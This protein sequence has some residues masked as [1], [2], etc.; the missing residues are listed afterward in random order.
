M[1]RTAIDTSPPRD[2]NDDF[3]D[4]VVA[5]RRTWT[6]TSI[7]HLS[8]RAVPAAEARGNVEQFIGHAQIPV[9]VVG[10]LRLLGDFEG[11]YA[12]PMATCEG[13]MV[14]SYQRG[15]KACADG[16]RVRVL[17]DGLI[18][19]PILTFDS[20]D[21]AIAAGRF[22]DA[23]RARLVAAA[24]ATT[25]H[26]KVTAL[27]W[28]ILGRRLLLRLEMTTGDAHGINMVT[29]AAGA[30][31][32]LIQGAAMT[33][34]H[35]H[36]VEKRATR[37]SW[38]GKWVVAEA[39][40]PEAVVVSQLKTTATALADLWTT[41]QLAFSRMGSPNHAIQIANGLAGIYIATGQ[42]AAYVAESSVGTL[43]LEARGGD[44]YATLDLP[45]LHAATVGGGTGKGTAAEGRSI[46]GAASA[47]ELAC[48]IGATLLAGEINLAASFLGDDFV[49]A[50]ERLGRNRPMDGPRRPG[51]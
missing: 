35:G 42:D 5:A 45:N 51:S 13:T 10:P 8:G 46:I 7:P 19:W 31:T 17:R 4:A 20:V 36:D 18:V 38:R 50:H 12:V 29:K 14:A 16:I 49:A 1:S 21:S 15:L 25:S 3:S 47:R 9:G 44:L 39:L 23:E 28:E 40:V 27:D 37:R 32:A 41:Y 11:T 26:G 34:L 48:V 6:G 33:L 2:R 43:S 22:V 24:E 30:M